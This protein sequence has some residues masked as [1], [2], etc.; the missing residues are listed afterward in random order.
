MDESRTPP[1]PCLAV[2][3]GNGLSRPICILLKGMIRFTIFNAR[4]GHSETQRW[5]LTH[6]DSSATM[7]FKS[8]S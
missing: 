6:L 7:H 3:I 1:P 4:V 8:T 5:Q 2:N